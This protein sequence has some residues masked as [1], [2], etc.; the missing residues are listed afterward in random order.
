MAAAYQHRIEGDSILV[1]TFANKQ[2][3]NVLLDPIS[4][5]IDGPI[6][7]R[8]GHNFPAQHVTKAH[9]LHRFIAK[10]QSESKGSAKINYVV[11]FVKVS[12]A[13]LLPHASTADADAC[14]CC[15]GV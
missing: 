1:L 15:G 11:G 7:N 14:A 3:M 2:A 8:S 5:T 12:A 4:D 6:K 9:P 10:L 13:L